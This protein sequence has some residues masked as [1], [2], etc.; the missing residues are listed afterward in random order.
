MTV[1]ELVELLNA[2]PPNARVAFD[3]EAGHFNVHL[4]QIDR[5]SYEPPADP[6]VVVLTS[7]EHRE[8]DCHRDCREAEKKA[9]ERASGTYRHPL[10]MD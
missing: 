5:V 1:Q 4:V 9:A 2:C 3:T 10:D 7:Y 8:H 6:N